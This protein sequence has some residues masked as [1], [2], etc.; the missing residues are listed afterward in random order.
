MIN[1]L[2]ETIADINDAG[3]STG[4]VLWV[5]TNDGKL[6]STWNEF[7]AIA[8]YD[9]DNG[10]GCQEVNCSLV[11]VFNDFT[12][13]SRVEYDGAENWAYRHVPKLDAESNK[14][15]AE[16]LKQTGW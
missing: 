8:D 2:A 12:W 1:L 16:D 4:D 11:I 10:F 3:K 14:L 5:G 6:R 9:Y 13:L 15:Q 7:A